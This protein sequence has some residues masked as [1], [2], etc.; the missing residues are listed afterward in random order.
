MTTNQLAYFYER[1]L[2][3][4]YTTKVTDEKIY[5]DLN[6]PGIEP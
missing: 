4:A 5:F 3:V 1:N 2:R 6:N